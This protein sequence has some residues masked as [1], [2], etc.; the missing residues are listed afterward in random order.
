MMDN[1]IRLDLEDWKLLTTVREDLG[2]KKLECIDG[3][4]IH[5]YRVLRPYDNS[6]VLFVFYQK[7][8]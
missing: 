8:N 1:G 7:C 4:G 5:S 3:G 6:N 2:P